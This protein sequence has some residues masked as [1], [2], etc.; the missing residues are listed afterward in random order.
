MR[1]YFCPWL[2]DGE[3]ST[4]HQAT[5]TRAERGGRLLAPVRPARPPE[6]AAVVPTPSHSA[7]HPPCPPRTSEGLI[8]N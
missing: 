8:D 4:C 5:E 7:R 1:I 6:A 3:G 2:M